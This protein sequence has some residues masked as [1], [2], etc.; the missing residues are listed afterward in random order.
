MLE[1]GW[2]KCN[3]VAWHCQVID[4]NRHS[5][6]LHLI[7]L[8]SSVDINSCLGLLFTNCFVQ[9][10]NS[11][12]VEAFSEHA[13]ND[14]Q[15]TRAA[16]KRIHR[17]HNWRPI[18]LFQITANASE[19]AK[20]KQVIIQR[21]KVLNA[22]H[23]RAN[24]S[25]H[26]TCLCL[27][28]FVRKWRDGV[29]LLNSW[30]FFQLGL[31]KSTVGDKEEQDSLRQAILR[32]D[33]LTENMLWRHTRGGSLCDCITIFDRL[34]GYWWMHQSFTTNFCGRQASKMRTGGVNMEEKILPTCSTQRQAR[35]RSD[36]DD[37]KHPCELDCRDDRVPPCSWLQWSH[38]PLQENCRAG[39]EWH[40][41]S[42]VQCK[43]TESKPYKATYVPMCKEKK[44]GSQ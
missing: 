24:V 22:T 12:I 36:S 13:V 16:R 2:G 17:C 39:D 40:H 32:S 38:Q 3:Y 37:D 21:P 19:Q 41:W 18:Y 35:C 8:T 1:G 14:A 29:T 4:E 33:L 20:S 6:G 7:L 15:Q 44:E 26:M 30:N 9:Q 25:T 10:Y 23:G 31:Q 28:T 43:E 5:V 11:F 34:L 42:G 27:A